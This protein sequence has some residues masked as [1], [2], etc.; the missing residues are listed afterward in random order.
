MVGPAPGNESPVSKAPR[1]VLVTGATGFL[2]SHVTRALVKAG[3]A[4]RVLVR[5]PQRLHDLAKLPLEVAV[6]DVLRRDMVDAAARDVSAI[7]H[8]AGIVSWRPRDRQELQRANV[9]GTLNVL[10]VAMRRRARVLHTS[11]V[12]TL[13]GTHR[14]ELFDETTAAV[15]LPFDCP[16]TESKRTAERLA[17]ERGADVVVLLPGIILGPGD[18]YLTSTQIVLSYLRGQLHHHMS[19]GGTYCDVRDAANAYVAALEHGLGGQRY[20][21]AGTNYSHEELRT[22]LRHLTGMQRTYPLPLPMAEWAAYWAEAA[23]VFGPHPLEDLT[24][25]V[26]RWGALHGYASS[27]KAEHVLGYRR[28][29]FRDTLRDTI[30]DLLERRAA[31]AATPQLRRL[32]HDR[33]PDGQRA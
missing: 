18:R 13:G 21:L 32:L 2:G 5:R 25:P 22:E 4:V 11:S 16:Y 6:G 24:L 1:K 29:D 33:S 19:G 17:L 12:A 15:P 23:S 14:P 28:R 9:E 8:C 10:D 26:V 20:I 27:R 31:Y 3:H 7:V 30:V